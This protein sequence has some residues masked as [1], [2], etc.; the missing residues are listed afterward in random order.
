MIRSIFIASS[1]LLIFA[2]NSE[3]ASNESGNAADFKTFYE[4]FL[5]DSTFQ[6]ERIVFP[7]DGIPDNADSA[8]L[9]N[10]N[11]K[12][13]KENW[14]VHKA[15]DP[16]ELGFSIQFIPFGDDLIIEKLTHNSGA[17]GMIRRFAKL[18]DGKWYLIFYAGLNP[19]GDSKPSSGPVDS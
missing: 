19:I 1:L 17:Y 11:F 7:L 14:R 10:G 4:K 8:T 12:W 3:S 9:V 18:E 5:T 6:I 16:E 2:C 13:T 15:F